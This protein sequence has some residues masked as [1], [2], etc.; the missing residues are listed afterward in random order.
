MN[1]YFRNVTASQCVVQRCRG[2]GA[3]ITVQFIEFVRFLQDM[4]VARAG[5]RTSGSMGRA[6]CRGVDQRG[7]CVGSLRAA[8]VDN[9]LMLGWILG[10]RKCKTMQA[11]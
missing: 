8:G 3:D 4:A 5:Q 10:K 9:G 6:C 1:H 2:F 11:A 7:H